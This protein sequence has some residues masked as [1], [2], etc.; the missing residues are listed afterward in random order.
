M[1]I[2]IDLQG[3]QSTSRFR[4]IGRYSNSLALAISKNYHDTHEIIIV[5]NEMLPESIETIRQMFHNILKKSNIRIWKGCAPVHSSDEKNNKRIESS[6]LLRESFLASLNPD[7]VLVMST[8]EGYNDNSIISQS[9]YYNIPTAVVFYDAIPFMQPEK[10]IN[11]LGKQFEKYYYSKLEIIKN[12]DLV[13]GI[14]KSSCREAIEILHIDE[15]KVSN[16]SSAADTLFHPREYNTNEKLEIFGKLSI[17]K[18]FLLYSGAT[19]ER[20]NHLG[21]IKA[22]SLLPKKVKSNYQLVFAGGIPLENHIKFK[23]EMKRCKLSVNDVIFTGRIS[24]EDFVALY[25]LCDLYVFPSY[26]EGFGLPALEAMQCGAATIGANTTSIPEVIGRE[27]ALFDPYDPLDIANKIEYVLTNDIFRNELQK[28]SLYH[29]KKFSWDSSA[30]KLMKSIENWGEYT[31]KR[32]L[33]KFDTQYYIDNLVKHIAEKS[34]KKS[35]LLKLSQ[36]ITFNHPQKAKKQLLIDVSELVKSDAKSGIQ[37]VVRS[38]L[39]ELLSSNLEYEIKAIYASAEKYG[40]KY[41]NKFI[42][43]FQNNKYDETIQDYPIDIA[44]DD[45]ILA[46][47]MSPHIQVAQKEYLQ[48]IKKMGVNIYFIIYDLLTIYHPEWWPNGAKEN[49]ENLLNT[50]ITSSDGICCISQDVAN[51]VNKYIVDNLD[52]DIIPPSVNYFHLGA[53]ITNSVPSKGLDNNTEEILSNIQENYSFLMVGT[54]EPRKGHIQTLAA[55][56]KLWS[57]NIDVNLVIVGKPAWMVDKFVE[58]LRTHP[59]LG[60]KLF[61]LESISD[62]YLEKVYEYSACLIAASEGEGFGLP[63]I[64]AAQKKLPIIARDLPIFREVA[65]QFAYYFPNTKN[66]EVLAD[67]ILTWLAL[68]KKDTHPKSHDMPWLTWKESSKQLLKCIIPKKESNIDA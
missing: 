14:S 53:D 23:N 48:N 27:D 20:K 45:I 15:K 31:H 36:S 10:Y 28:H 60:I 37:R 54:I 9:T 64:E 62:E 41:A 7:I 21:L 34:H 30:T 3:A 47:D 51:D 49:F 4:G 12:A 55:F 56:E 59:K 57:D 68:Y 26:H 32:N 18:P 63:L 25:N 40:Y 43:Q 61:F 5:L 50:I 2:I 29:S 19:D 16:I 58:Q 42:Y 24:D 33:K 46:L 6:S 8:I 22:F 44:A 17:V 11:P 65:Q 66:E 52:S 38:I 1:R 39:N 35:D 13:F 67:T